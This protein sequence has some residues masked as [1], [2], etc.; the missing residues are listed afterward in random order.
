MIKL[1]RSKAIIDRQICNKFQNELLR[2]DNIVHRSKEFDEDGCKRDY[3]KNEVSLFGE[4]YKMCK[5]RFANST[6]VNFEFAFFI[7]EPCE[8]KES[9][10]RFTVEIFA[11]VKYGS[12]R[13]IYTINVISVKAFK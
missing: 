1:L 3:I 11:D 6:G 8:N 12:I 5:N 10:Q 2:E 13:N 9:I 7:L 4:R